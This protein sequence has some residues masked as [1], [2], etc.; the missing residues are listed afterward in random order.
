MQSAPAA[1]HPSEMSSALG[2]AEANEISSKGISTD[3]RRSAGPDRRAIR[4]NGYVGEGTAPAGEYHNADFSWEEHCRE[5]QA[6]IAADPDRWRHIAQDSMRVL[7]SL[8]APGHAPG[9]RDDMGDLASSSHAAGGLVLGTN[10]GRSPES[11]QDD[12]DMGDLVSQS[13]AAGGVVMSQ[14]SGSHAPGTSMGTDAP[15]KV[16]GGH[17]GDQSGDLQHCLSVKDQLLTDD[18]HQQISH[19]QVS[20]SVNDTMQSSCPKPPLSQHRLAVPAAPAAAAAPAHL[21]GDAP[22]IA[23]ADAEAGLEG[24]AS[25]YSS[26]RWEAFHAQD[27]RSGRFYKERR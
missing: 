3:S 9:G 21:P 2:A 27:N 5:V 18:C 19:A 24:P 25:G 6:M 15:S 7:G 4:C 1:F 16:S 8:E 20:D 17:N 10:S 11:G 22:E 23:E 26:S 12:D 14:N 13:T